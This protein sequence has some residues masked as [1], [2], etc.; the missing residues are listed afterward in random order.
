M[1][2][3][4]DADSLW[5]RECVRRLVPRQ[6]S[7]MASF[8]DGLHIDL[9]DMLA[10]EALGLVAAMGEGEFWAL[11]GVIDAFNARFGPPLRGN[12][13]VRKIGELGHDEER[14]AVFSTI[15]G[16][17]T[18]AQALACSC[19]SRRPPVEPSAKAAS[20]VA[21]PPAGEPGV[22]PWHGSRVIAGENPIGQ[23]VQ[24]MRR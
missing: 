16:G 18:L 8:R 11:P 4:S 5:A 9:H 23:I 6:V 13:E 19:T 22:H 15:A 3:P 20:G 14:V 10:L 2:L 7:R 1:S 21:V 24:K 17:S 12:H